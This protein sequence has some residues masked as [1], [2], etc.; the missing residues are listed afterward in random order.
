MGRDARMRLTEEQIG[1]I[2][3]LII[4]RGGEWR[5]EVGNISPY[6]EYYGIRLYRQD[7]DGSVQLC[8]GR[9]IEDAPEAYTLLCKVNDLVTRLNAGDVSALRET[10][11]IPLRG[12]ERDD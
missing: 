12:L 7:G 5:E 10:D 6:A 1:E 8:V 2:A 4:E 9:C 3:L 11:F